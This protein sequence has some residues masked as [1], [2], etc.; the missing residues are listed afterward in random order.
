[1][2]QIISTSTDPPPSD[3]DDPLSGAI[4]DSTRVVTS[5]SPRPSRLSV[6]PAVGPLSTHVVTRICLCA[7]H[8]RSHPELRTHWAPPFMFS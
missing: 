5:A 3:S 1:V 8:H 2:S 4:P 7:V 6:H